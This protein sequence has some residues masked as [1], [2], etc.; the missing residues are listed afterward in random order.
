LCA[1]HNRESTNKD[2]ERVE[3]G[4]LHGVERLESGV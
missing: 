2:G 3:E 1:A 4:E